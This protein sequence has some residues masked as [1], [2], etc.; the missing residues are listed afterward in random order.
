M[1]RS[2]S[3]LA[4]LLLLVFVTPALAATPYHVIDLGTLGGS[5]SQAAAVNDNN[6]VVGVSF[7][8]GDE[9]IR[10][11]FYSN[12]SMRPLPTFGGDTYANAL[13][14]ARM[15]VGDSQLTLGGNN[16]GY[17]Y[18]AA[19]PGGDTLHDVGTLDGPTSLLL[20][21]N[22]AGD[23]VGISD[24]N[25]PPE[26]G[27]VTQRAILYRNG[28]MTDL[29][30]FGGDFAGATAINDKGQVV[31]FASF[32]PP[33]DPGESVR[34]HAFLWE[35]G[36]KKDLGTLPD[37]T[38]SEAF[39]INENGQ[40][41]GVSSTVFGTIDAFI[42]DTDGTI[43]PLGSLVG[44]RSTFAAG[45]NNAGQVVGDAFINEDDTHA[46][47]W[48]NGQVHDLNDLLDDPN[49]P[50]ELTTAADIN[51]NGVIVGTGVINGEEHAF[52]AVPI[53]EP[54]TLLP[55]L[56]SIAVLRRTRSS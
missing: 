13:N 14:N 54:A 28:Q 22:A 41:V 40:V 21:V 56:L 30:T 38:H 53:P 23:M 34:N 9:D 32:P 45:I 50:W 35:N 17:Y 1:S 19:L 18:N 39:A 51:N 16:H 33:P 26:Q 20:G 10:A 44:T 36:V 15:V 6:D 43:K 27:G 12:G 5:I 7:V 49:S 25:I 24:K 55:A 48:E 52:M 3:R 2:A 42:Y 29:G 46:T 8:T 11:F 37:D 4:P 31:G 47:L